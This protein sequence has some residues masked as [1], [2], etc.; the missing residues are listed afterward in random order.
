MNRS[1]VVCSLALALIGCS[2]P[3]VQ[4]GGIS[5]SKVIVALKPDKNPETMLAE[6]KALEA[7]LSDELG[8]KV[9]VI[10]PLAPAVIMEGMANGTVDLAYVSA[11]E[12]LMAYNT[13]AAEILVAGEINGKTSYQSYW[14]ALSDKPYSGVSDLAGRPVAFASRTSTSGCI[15][16]H[17][18]L[19]R[20]GHLPERAD[21]EQ[22]FGKGNVHYGTGY[23]SAVDRVLRGEVE[24]AAV[25][26]YVLDEDKHLSP[27]DRSRLKKVAEQGPVPTHVIAVRAG[28]SQSDRALLRRAI[29]KLNEP[30]QEEL[31][32]KVFTSR[33]VEVDPEEHLASLREALILTGR[34]A[35]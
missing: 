1:C 32:D 6:K 17:W 4:D 13:G 29:L 2:N 21:P 23:V 15:I 27:A 31:R 22:F 9:E 10:I 35:P 33:V 5:L 8:R 25:S 24:A 16:P 12:M 3:E 20:K 34:L 18:D 14:V 28:L 11:T 26:Y 19:I 7:F 30:G